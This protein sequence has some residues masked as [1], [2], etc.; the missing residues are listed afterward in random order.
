MPEP[1]QKTSID[2]G[3]GEKLPGVCIVCGTATSGVK[4]VEYERPMSFV[5]IIFR[6]VGSMFVRNL[7]EENQQT[8]L[9]LFPLCDVHAQIDPDLG[10]FTI[11]P[12]R[13]R[14][15]L[16]SPVA[17]EFIRQTQ[18]ARDSRAQAIAEQFKGMDT[19]TPQGFFKSLEEEK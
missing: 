13:A 7:P 9:L 6:L 18:M 16:V 19:R 2:I 11:R 17:A 8:F 5:E 12:H 10:H 14:S 4:T 15:V 3:F 1:D